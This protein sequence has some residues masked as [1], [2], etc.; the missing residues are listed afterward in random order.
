MR[1][2]EMMRRKRELERLYWRCQ[3]RYRDGVVS[4]ALAELFGVGGAG[5]LRPL[6]IAYAA[7]KRDGDAGKVDPSGTIPLR[8]WALCV[9]AA[10]LQLARID[11]DLV[12]W[13]TCL[14]YV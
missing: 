9:A 13:G 1:Q 12:G 14:F 10:Q 4:T 7:G 11:E 5:C 8:D 2:R 6:D 3:E